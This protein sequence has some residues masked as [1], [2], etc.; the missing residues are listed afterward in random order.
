MVWNLEN[1]RKRIGDEVFKSEYRLPTTPVGTPKQVSS[2]KNSRVSDNYVYGDSKF[3]RIDCA[4]PLFIGGYSNTV[5]KRLHC[6]LNCFAR[7]R[8]RGD[9][10]RRCLPRSWAR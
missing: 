4:C 3:V 8:Q 1:G 2:E 5:C 10:H 7:W 9:N 6:P